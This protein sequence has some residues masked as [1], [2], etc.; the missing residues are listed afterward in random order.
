MNRGGAIGS[1]ERPAPDDVARGGSTALLFAA[2]VGDLESAR[3]LLDAGAA[4][5][6]KLADGTSALLL[7]THSG[8]GRLAE[9]LLERGANPNLAESGYAPLHAAVLVGDRSLVAALLAHK[10]NPNLRQTKGNPVRRTG[11]DLVLPNSL[12]G[13][14]PYYLAARFGE[15][16]MMQMLIEAGADP[17]LRTADGTSPLMTAAGLGW[18]LPMNRRGVD[19]TSKKSAWLGQTAEEAINLRAVQTALRFD[20]DVNAVNSLGET[21]LL[22]PSPRGSRTSPSC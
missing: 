13:A 19:I 12:I 10:A 11:E 16:E 2:R 6:D 1:S 9:L 5:N 7:A 21:A 8:H 15:V 14:T 18:A 22:A 4:V 20:Q 17:K 3:L